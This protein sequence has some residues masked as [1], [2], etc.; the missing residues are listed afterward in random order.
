MNPPIDTHAV[1]SARNAVMRSASP[2]VASAAMLSCCCTIAAPAAAQPIDQRHDLQVM[3]FASRR[4]AS[5]PPTPCSS[6]NSV[7]GQRRLMA[8]DRIDDDTHRRG[9]PR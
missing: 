2:P 5:R 1:T 4:I 7:A 6:T 9:R 8:E 3:R